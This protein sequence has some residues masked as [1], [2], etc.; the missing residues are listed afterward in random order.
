MTTRAE[1]RANAEHHLAYA[2]AV[3]NTDQWTETTAAVVHH[4]NT[5]AHV[6]ALLAMTAPAEPVPLFA[7]G[8]QDAEAY[9]DGFITG[10]AR[11]GQA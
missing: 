4:H 8:R 10:Q 2:A 5:Q 11:T 9:W 3:A 1:H 6:E 7:N